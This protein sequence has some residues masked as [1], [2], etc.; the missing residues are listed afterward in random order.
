MREGA[1]SGR[2]IVSRRENKDERGSRTVKCFWLKACPKC[3]IRSTATQS[4][5]EKERKSEQKRNS[6]RKHKKEADVIQTT[7]CASIVAREP[8]DD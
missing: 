7:E 4:R 2:E 5:E 3:A 1:V 6:E 8:A